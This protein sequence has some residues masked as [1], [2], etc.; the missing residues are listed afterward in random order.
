MKIIALID[1]HDVIEKILRHLDLWT[2]EPFGARAPPS[3]STGEVLIE[4]WLD[5][6]MPDYE[7]ATA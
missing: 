1:R 3:A 4:P 7:S 5:D 2:G 6:P